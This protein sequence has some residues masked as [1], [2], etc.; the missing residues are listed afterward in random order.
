[1]VQGLCKYFTL[2]PRTLVLVSIP[3]ITYQSINEL[4]LIS[5]FSLFI[6]YIWNVYSRLISSFRYSA[7]TVQDL[8]E[9]LPLLLY[10]FQLLSE[11]LLSYLLL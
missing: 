6:K 4:E 3:L 9:K 7:G 8:L 11:S 5:F 2:D 10:L 1:M